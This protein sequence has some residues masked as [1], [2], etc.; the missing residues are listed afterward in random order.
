MD[1]RS[2][3]WALKEV[4]FSQWQVVRAHWMEESGMWWVMVEARHHD[5]VMH[6]TGRGKNISEAQDQATECL[7]KDVEKW[8][9]WRKQ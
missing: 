3:E 4:W 9:K 1:D 5:R 6:A 7:L 8:K 2:M